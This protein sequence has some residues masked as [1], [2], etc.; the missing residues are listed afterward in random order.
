[1]YATASNRC[2]TCRNQ[3]RDRAKFCPLCGMQLVA[4]PAPQPAAAAKPHKKESGGGFA[5]FLL[6]LFLCGRAYYARHHVAA[7]TLSPALK[8]TAI[9][10]NDLTWTGLQPGK[11]P[12]LM[13]PLEERS[14]A[15]GL[16][17]RPTLDTTMGPSLLP[18]P[19]PTTSRS[20]R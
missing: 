16:V 19:L 15:R 10:G 9:H 12:A 6:I 3:L 13:P 5:F 11:R 1:M 17:T 2:P 14:L 8:S 4:P 20:V 7:A 18:T